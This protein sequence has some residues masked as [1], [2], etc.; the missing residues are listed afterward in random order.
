MQSRRVSAVLLALTAAVGALSTIHPARA[1]D[2]CRDVSLQ[3]PGPAAI[4][5]GTVA[6]LGSASIDNFNFYKVEWAPESQPGSWSAVSATVAR[7][8]DGGLLDRWNTAVVADG[9]YRLKLTVVDLQGQETCRRTITRLQVANAPPGPSAQA[10]ADAASTATG[11][12]EPPTPAA[13]GT[14]TVEADTESTP[15]SG[16]TADDAG[17]DEAPASTGDAAAEGAT[18]PTDSPPVEIA[19]PP[20]PASAGVLPGFGELAFCFGATFLAT[21]AAALWL[22]RRRDA[23]TG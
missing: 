23:W 1:Q 10:S 20:V 19:P 22:W 11:A 13:D 18:Q 14:A 8:V 12:S 9:L 21:L 3:S 5:S 4:I 15:L 2:P 16:A 6:V 7:P 17:T